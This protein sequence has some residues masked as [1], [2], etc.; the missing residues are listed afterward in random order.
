MDSGNPDIE[1]PL[2][3]AERDSDPEWISRLN[4]SD[5]PFRSERFPELLDFY[6]SFDELDVTE[7]DRRGYESFL[8]RLDAG[9]EDLLNRDWNF[10]VV[11]LRN[12]GGLVMPVPVRITYSSGKTEDQH[13]PAELWRTN[14]RVISRLLVT[15]EPVVKVEIDPYLE[16]ADADRSNNAYPQEIDQKRFRIR[17]DS[18][19]SNPM[20]RNRDEQFLREAEIAAGRLGQEIARRMASNT[21]GTPMPAASGII[22]ELRQ[23]LFNDPFGSEFS[24]FDFA[25]EEGI[26]RIF[27]VGPDG[28]PGTDDDMTWIV[29]KDGHID[30][31]VTQD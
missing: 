2:Q 14:P 22:S 10:T 11:R 29:N 17:P 16:I 25:G 30:W 24:V 18:D 19:R 3:K 12:Y 7:E 5:I 15:P 8:A 13:L 26:A 1:K 31:W 23:D 9:D 6:N 21:A 4:N 28:D 20:Q 27:S